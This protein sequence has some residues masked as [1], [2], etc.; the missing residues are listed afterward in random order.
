[1]SVDD[2]LKAVLTQEIAR[3]IPS[4]G[5]FEGSEPGAVWVSGFR[6]HGVPLDGELSVRPAQLDFSEV[7]AV[8]VELKVPYPN[9]LVRVNPRADGRVK[10]GTK[11]AGWETTEEGVL[12]LL[13]TPFPSSDRSDDNSG[14]HQAEQVR[15]W[16]RLIIARSIIVATLGRNAAYDELFGIKLEMNTS[17][18]GFTTV[19]ENPM[20][21]PSPPLEVPDLM[22][23]VNIARAIDVAEE[24]TQNSVRSALRWYQRALGDQR[25]MSQGTSDVDGLLNY[26]VALEILTRTGG[27]GAAGAILQQ[28]ADI[29]GLTM[30]RAGETFPISGIYKMRKRIIHQGELVGVHGRLLTFLSD[31]FFD[32]L[33]RTLGLTAPLRTRRWL[34]EDAYRFLRG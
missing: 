19:F 23:V 10:D 17:D 2:V 7:R 20:S 30:Q 12:L 14:T 3:F 27:K 28:L 18:L 11:L 1:M 9:F 15:A 4:V 31:V 34:H 5:W 33:V 21:F 8:F 6:V 16:E 29:H 13:I 25:T 32:V 24:G 26:W 22:L